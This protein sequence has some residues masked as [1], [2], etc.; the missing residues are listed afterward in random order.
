MKLKT[1]KI[2]MKNINQILIISIIFIIFIVI[3]INSVIS[4]PSGATNLNPLSNQTAPADSPES[5]SA[6]AGNV[7]EIN[8]FGFSTTQTWQGYFG[9]VTGVI[10]LTNQAN[11]TMYNWSQ[12][13]PRGE[14]YASNDSGILW[15]DLQCF[16]YSANG[17]S[18]NPGSINPGGTSSCGMNITQLEDSFGIDDI[19]V[20]GVNETFNLNNHASFYTN[21]LYFGAGEC[22]NS[23]IY[24]NNGQGLFDE[25]LLYS[26]LRNSIIFAS[27]LRDNSMGFDGLSHDFEMLVLE[28]G[29][30]TD[31]T[32][33]TYYFY[34]ELQ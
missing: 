34:I 7:S 27:L 19:D 1:N 16:N 29:H 25:V 32:V 8:I 13:N 28:N 12:A 10:E 18:C 14:V 30:G 3:Q 20:D 15:T 11:H 21:N 26:P 6:V 5:I 31:T 2:K 4:L 22:N 9:N 24:D 33:S 17:T 23:K